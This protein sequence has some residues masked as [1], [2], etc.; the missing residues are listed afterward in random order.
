MFYGSDNATRKFKE[1]FNADHDLWT[2]VFVQDLRELPGGPPL[3][4][5]QLENAYIDFVR[6]TTTIPSLPWKLQAMNQRV[7]KNLHHSV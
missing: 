6:Q 4:K 2:N 5:S 1:T 3:T 7:K